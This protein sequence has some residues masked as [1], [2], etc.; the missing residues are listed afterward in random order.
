[1]PDTRLVYDAMTTPR[2]VL[3]YFTLLADGGVVSPTPATAWSTCWPPSRST[4][5]FRPVCRAMEAGGSPTRPPTSTTMLGDAGIVY[6]P[7]AD[8]YALI[9]LNEGLTSYFSSVQT[10]S[11][12]L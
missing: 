2:D 5:A 10:T 1:M 3:G 7:N 11:I 12:H 6:L 8:A 9:I 4:I